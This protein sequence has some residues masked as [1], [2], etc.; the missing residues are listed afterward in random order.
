MLPS[1]LVQVIVILSTAAP[2]KVAGVEIIS[3]PTSLVCIVQEP[4]AL[5]V[6]SLRDH[7]KGASLMLT[8]TR[9]PSSAAAVRARLMGSPDVPA[10]AKTVAPLPFTIETVSISERLPPAPVCPL[11]FVVIVKV[12]VL[13]FVPPLNAMPFKALFISVTVPVNVIALEA[14]AP[15]L[16]VSPVIVER[17]RIPVELW[18]EVPSDNDTV[19]VLAPDRK[20]TR[21]NSSHT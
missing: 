10:G 16:N 3:E 15:A 9:M 1:A 20:S 17:V 6:P 13:L 8:V 11:S 19:T 5:W 18:A 21:L 14:L 7:P 2:A 12:R 4:S